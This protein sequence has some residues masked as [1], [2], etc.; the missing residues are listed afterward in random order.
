M[1]PIEHVSQLAL[2]HWN[3]QMVFAFAKCGMGDA[4]QGSRQAAG[5]IAERCG[6]QTDATFRLLRALATLGIVSQDTDDEQLFELT[7]AGELLTSDHPTSMVNKVLLEAGYEHVVMWTH[8]T[9]HL[10]TGVLAPKKVF[11]ADNFWDLFESRAGYR[12]VFST[13]MSSYTSDEIQ[14]ILAMETLDLSG[15]G[16][17][18]DVGGSY[19]HLIGALLEK[20]PDMRATLF[21]MP[22]VVAAVTATDRMATVGGDFFQGVPKG[23][24]AY[25]LKHILHDW[26][27]DRCLEL[28]GHVVEAMPPDG[29]VL[30]GEFGPMPGPGQPHLS[31]FFDLHMMLNLKGRERDLGEW[32]A[33]LSKA[34]LAIVATHS[35]FGPL[36]V[37]EAR[38]AS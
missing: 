32:Q 9:E 12:E 20:Y 15:V 27:D 23:A 4:F 10:K 22:D 24:D 33:L 28:L 13:A 38:R 1:N 35:S 6:L 30:I 16:H 34:G 26:D 17:L 2:A 21:D 5:V 3:S 19:G 29:R 8:L 18:V 37:I 7:E 11:D 36:S 31:K 14:M 25:M